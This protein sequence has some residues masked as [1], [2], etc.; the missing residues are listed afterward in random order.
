MSEPKKYA[1]FGVG[2]SGTTDAI[3]EAEAWVRNNGNGAVYARLDVTEQETVTDFTTQL[4]VVRGALRA[5]A[6]LCRQ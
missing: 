6:E 2:F 3:G 5:I 4:A 1:A